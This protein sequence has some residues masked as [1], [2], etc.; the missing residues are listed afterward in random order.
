MTPT[1]PLAARY[2]E[3]ATACLIIAKCQENERDR[4]V[5]IDMAQ[6]WLALANYAVKSESMFVTPEPQP[7]DV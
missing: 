4:L 3:Y 5:L 2:R 7:D 1:E 6:A